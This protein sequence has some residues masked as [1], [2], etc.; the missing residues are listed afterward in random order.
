MENS[1]ELGRLDEHNLEKPVS[2]KTL[3]RSTF[4]VGEMGRNS[5]VLAIYLKIELVFQDAN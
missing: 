4:N 2:L 3:A 1:Q 5:L